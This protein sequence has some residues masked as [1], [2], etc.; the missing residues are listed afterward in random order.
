MEWQPLKTAPKDGTQ[1][2]LASVDDGGYGVRQGFY[3]PAF[4]S[5]A[6]Y[7]IDGEEV[8]PHYWMPLPPAPPLPKGDL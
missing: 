1:V 8:E 4:G 3:E 5:R 7:D 2:L 6:W